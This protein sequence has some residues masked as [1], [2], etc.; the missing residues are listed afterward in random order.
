MNYAN[1]LQFR[2][3][4]FV[5]S[6]F[7]NIKGGAKANPHPTKQSLTLHCSQVRFPETALAGVPRVLRHDVQTGALLV[8]KRTPSGRCCCCIIQSLFCFLLNWL[9]NF[10]QSR[11][12]T[13][14]ASEEQR[15]WVVT[16]PYPVADLN[17]STDHCQLMNPALSK[18]TSPP[19]VVT[20]VP[21]LWL[22]YIRWWR[23]QIKSSDWTKIKPNL[24]AK[25]NELKQHKLINHHEYRSI[26]P[27]ILTVNPIHQPCTPSSINH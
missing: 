9:I 13:S 27:T 21:N 16:T 4:F 25:S 2:G 3:H 8:L 11:T 15:D 18:M 17:T 5:H 20:G 6:K 7:Q 23:I 22:T 24:V 19:G 26:S 12:Y 10:N 1:K 14:G